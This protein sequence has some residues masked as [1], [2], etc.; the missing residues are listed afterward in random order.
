VSTLEEDVDL[1]VQDLETINLINGNSY[2]L[3]FI[4]E[5]AKDKKG[6]DVSSRATINWVLSYTEDG[7][8]SYI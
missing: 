8:K 2:L 6:K 3:N 5:P 1:E 4:V 7:G